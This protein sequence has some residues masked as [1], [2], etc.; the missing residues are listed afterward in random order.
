MTFQLQRGST[1]PS[2]PCRP[3]MEMRSRW[4]TCVGGR[5]SCIPTQRPCRLDAPGRLATSETTLIAEGRWL[6]GAGSLAR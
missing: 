1:A 5:R 2:S 4:M 3:Q 6:C